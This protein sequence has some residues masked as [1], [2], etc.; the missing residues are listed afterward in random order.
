MKFKQGD[1]V[2]II[3]SRE[4]N[5]VPQAIITYLGMEAIVAHA[6]EEA[7]LYL[8]AIDG[9]PGRIPV[10]FNVAERMIEPEVNEAMLAAA[11]DQIL[12][13]LKSGAGEAGPD[14]QRNP[15][16]RNNLARNLYRAMRAARFK[17]EA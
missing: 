10:T 1:H 4:R 12:E 13:Y 9:V 14:L 17:R 16:E 7:K 11:S 2:R 15:E 6:N 3:E 5:G 8:I